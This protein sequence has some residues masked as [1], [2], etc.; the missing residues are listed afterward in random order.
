MLLEKDCFLQH[1]VI[2]NHMIEEN[3]TKLWK[4]YKAK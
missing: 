2:Q 3:L 4:D 1:Y